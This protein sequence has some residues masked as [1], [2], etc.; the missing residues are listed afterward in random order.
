[1]WYIMC[2]S[3]RA[4]I[5]TQMLPFQEQEEQ[6]EA[7]GERPRKKRQQSAKGGPAVLMFPPLHF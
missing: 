3:S 2:I 5:Y 1:M 7:P 4:A 6:K